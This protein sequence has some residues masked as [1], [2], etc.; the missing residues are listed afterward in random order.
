MLQEFHH[1][2]KLGWLVGTFLWHW[3]T[4][5]PTEG[6]NN[7]AFFAKVAFAVE[8]WEKLMQQNLSCSIHL[9]RCEFAGSTTQFPV[10]LPW[11]FGTWEDEGR[12]IHLK[13]VATLVVASNVNHTLSH[14]QVVGGV[15]NG[16]CWGLDIN[17]LHRIGGIGFPFLLR[18][19]SAQARGVDPG[20][21]LDLVLHGFFLL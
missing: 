3:G 19:W 6:Q 9:R 4:L 2:V 11:L 12:E 20:L 15:E 5:W 14:T 7:V 18:H 16:C 10:H 21:C 8:L 17:N 1:I 13:R